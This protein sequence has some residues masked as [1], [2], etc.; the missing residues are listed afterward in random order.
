MQRYQ[1]P[2]ARRAF[3]VPGRGLSGLGDA[4]A[5]PVQWRAT[6]YISG[7]NGSWGECQTRFGNLL[8]Q[9]GFTVSRITYDTVTLLPPTYALIFNGYA[10]QG[11]DG[12]ESLVADIA[13]NAGFAVERNSITFHH[14]GTVS[15]GSNNGNG[16]G[17]GDDPT[18]HTQLYIAGAV[19]LAAL[20]LFRH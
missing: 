15:P 20:L 17:G 10:P 8:A 7:L 4:G 1:F 9:R 11:I 13:E 16:G 14:G 18:D 19:V 5:E 12:A 6:A 2:P 3:Y